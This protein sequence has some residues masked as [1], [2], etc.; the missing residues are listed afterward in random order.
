LTQFSIPWLTL[1][2]EDLPHPPRPD[3]QVTL[4]VPLPETLWLIWFPQ[5]GQTT[6]MTIWAMVIPRFE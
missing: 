4:W 2:R 6:V 1:T 5:W 3:W